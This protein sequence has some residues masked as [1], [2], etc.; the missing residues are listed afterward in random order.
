MCVSGLRL[1]QRSCEDCCAAVWTHAAAQLDM[2]QCVCLLNL[3]RLCCVLL[4]GERG[5]TFYIVES[6]QLS[7]FKDNATL[8]VL[9][10]GPGGCHLRSVEGPLCLSAWWAVTHSEEALHQQQACR[11][12]VL[13]L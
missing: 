10:Y 7:A 4:Q 12:Y 3:G 11:V 8:P 9:S 6:G 2:A 1:L 13:M 5:H